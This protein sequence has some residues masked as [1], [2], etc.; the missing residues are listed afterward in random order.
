[1]ARLLVK[2]EDF[3]HPDPAQDRIGSYK[4]GDVVCVMPDG[5][6]CGS[7]EGLPKFEQVDMP[8]VSVDEV[9]HLAM[10]ETE[11]ID[12]LV[13]TAARKNKRLLRLLAKTKKRD[14]KTRRRFNVD[15]ATQQITDKTR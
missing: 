8:G 12:E 1:M 6:V 15:L 3:T 9:K 13:S 5:H 14:A 11:T 4:R 2:A 10:S 7:K